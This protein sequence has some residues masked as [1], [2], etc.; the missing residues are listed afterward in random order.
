[1]ASNE[2]FAQ[3][4]VVSTGIWLCEIGK[5]TGQMFPSLHVLFGLVGCDIYSV[6]GENQQLC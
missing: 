5:R 6:S 1:M 3:C 4:G 2:K